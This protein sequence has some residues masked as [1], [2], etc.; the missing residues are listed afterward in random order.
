MSFTKGDDI[1]ILQKTDLGVVS[2]GKGNDIYIIDDDVMAPN[3][4]IQI[5][6]E[7]G[8]NAVHLLDGLI[9][10]EAIVA[11]NALELVLDNG[12]KVDILNA[13]DYKFLLGGDAIT[14]K[15]GT[16]QTFNDFVTK[17]LGLPS[18]PTNGLEKA[19]DITI[20]SNE[21]NVINV[22][23]NHTFSGTNGPDE[24]K[25][26]AVSAL[27]DTNGTN[28][29]A[30]ITNFDVS[31]D[32]L[33][34]VLPS[35]D[36]N[37]TNL[38]ELN[39]KEGISVSYNPFSNATIIT[40]GND[41]N[42]GEAVTLTLDGISQDDWNKVMI[43]HAPST[44]NTVSSG[45]NEGSSSNSSC[46]CPSN[47]NITFSLIPD[48]NSV[49]E[50]HD[51]YITVKA[52]SPVNQDTILYYKIVPADDPNYN[53]ASPGDLDITNAVVIPKGQTS[54]KI[55]VFPWDDEKQEG[56]EA[57]KV[58]LTDK[59]GNILAETGELLVHDPDG[60]TYYLTPG[61]D[62]IQGTNK[63]DTIIGFVSPDS[64]ENTLNPDDMID[65]G[66]ERD[67]ARLHLKTD[68]NGFSN[69]GYIDNV[70]SFTLKNEAG[71]DITFNAKNIWGMSSLCLGGDNEGHSININNLDSKINSLGLFH[72]YDDESIGL[73]TANFTGYNDSLTLWLSDV[74][75]Y[76]SP[77][78]N[79]AVKISM[80]GVENI[81]IVT[82]IPTW[83]NNKVD[84]VDLSGMTSVRNINVTNGIAE[85]RIDGVDSNLTYF[86]GSHYVGDIISD[87]S[88]ASNIDIIKTGYGN[89]TITVSSG[90]NIID[91]GGG[92]NALII[93]NYYVDGNDF[94]INN[95]QHI[96]LD[97]N[98]KPITAYFT[99]QSEPLYINVNGD[100][101]AT[102][103]GGLNNDRIVGG[104]G[105][106]TIIGGPGAD[107][108]TG[109]PGNDIFVLMSKNDT[110]YSVVYDRDGSGN[111]SNGDKICGQFDVITDFQTAASG[112]GDKLDINAISGINNGNAGNIIDLDYHQYE[113]IRGNWDSKTG[114]FIVDSNNGNDELIKF[115]IQGVNGDDDAAV[116]LL[117]V[118]N[119]D[120][121][122]DFAVHS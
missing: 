72:I 91:G 108:L 98:E 76:N 23:D 48:S 45:G 84:Y 95:I 13:N 120:A 85:L 24:F 26:D 18:I 87:F 59:D 36:S 15:N 28:T 81:N 117:G 11:S 78:D 75:Y 115:D 5:A 37:I 3:Q 114:T 86:D 116:V 67:K 34:L 44:N 104:P 32:F 14:G 109:G 69:S 16:E 88:N 21:Y 73:G 56:D 19:Y 89:D 1:N 33:Y 9:I 41:Q 46:T 8:N 107:T 12:A 40:F 43:N 64:S 55:G 101:G 4:Q 63:T 7:E 79:K 60:E 100:N 65:G 49:V 68:F 121:Q 10:K 93:N 30:T 62:I 96:I 38:S 61:Q 99:H 51:L 77:S 118:T 103:Y 122:S 105:N 52:S 74:G 17:T 22:Y 6:D 27:Q 119:F 92:Y 80:D 83:N 54:A 110:G 50:N 70:E 58:A 106:D 29:Q 82:E 71:R 90:N 31:Q 2:A 94:A 111:I 102:V 112:G 39:G 97:T 53:N 35:P 113:I 20:G 42:G 57:F 25:F 66:G 47:S